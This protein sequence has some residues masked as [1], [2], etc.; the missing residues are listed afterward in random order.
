MS[1]SIKIATDCD[2]EYCGYHNVVSDGLIVLQ[3]RT[4]KE[5][6]DYI[7]MMEKGACEIKRLSAT[8]GDELIKIEYNEQRQ[9]G[10]QTS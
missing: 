5:C 3:E 6:E 7:E 4:R 8:G 9:A 1:L 10:F 2:G